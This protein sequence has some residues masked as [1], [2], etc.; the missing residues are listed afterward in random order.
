MGAEGLPETLSSYSWMYEGVFLRRLEAGSHE[1]GVCV[2]E[3]ELVGE[4]VLFIP[5]AVAPRPNIPEL[6]EQT[7]SDNESSVREQ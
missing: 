2:E 1:K 7:N 5:Q 6:D 3:R 4:M